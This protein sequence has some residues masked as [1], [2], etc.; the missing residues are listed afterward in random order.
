MRYLRLSIPL[1]SVHLSVRPSVLFF[2]LLNRQ[3]I[4]RHTN[5][6]QVRNRPNASHPELNPP[7]RITFKSDLDKQGGVS[8]FCRF[9][10]KLVSARA[11]L[12]F[13]QHSITFNFF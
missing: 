1:C 3:V 11:N 5:R 8:L 7:V 6:E 2:L 13:M 9:V 12:G 10:L 4:T